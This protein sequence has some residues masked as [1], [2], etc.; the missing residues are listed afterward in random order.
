MNTFVPA[1]MELEGGSLDDF[2]LKS[3][4]PYHASQSIADALDRAGFF[5]LEETDEWKIKLGESYYVIRNDTSI[6]A[7]R[8][9]Q[10]S[11]LI[12]RVAF[13]WCASGQSML[14]TQSESVLP[15]TWL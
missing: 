10:N 4:T 6:V 7:F 9:G 8:N 13:D 14:E 11:P 1:G 5:R 2:L 12:F 15:G 3:P